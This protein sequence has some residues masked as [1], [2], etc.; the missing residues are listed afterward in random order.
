M[1]KQND[2]EFVRETFHDFLKGRGEAP[3]W[4]VGSEPP[5]Y[6]L[7]LGDRRYSVEVTQVMEEFQIGSGRQTSQAIQSFL[8]GVAKSIEDE[9]RSRGILHGTYNLSARAVDNFRVIQDAVVQSALEYI[10]QT[11]HM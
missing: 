4:E 8:L 2:E 7:M 6:F 9:A 11:Q 3:L 10:E 1:K 5:D